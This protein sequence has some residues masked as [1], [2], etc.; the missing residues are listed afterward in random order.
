M[1][2]DA[3]SDFP[4]AQLPTVFADGVINLA[5]TSSIAKFYLARNDPSFTGDNRNRMQIF[6]QV[7]MPLSGFLQ[8]FAFFERTI[9]NMG[10]NNPIIIQELAAAREAWKK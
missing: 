10:K 4:P 2:E 8:A 1:T 7:V 6:A 3:P 9:D 5:T